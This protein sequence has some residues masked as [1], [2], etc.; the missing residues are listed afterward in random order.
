MILQYVRETVSSE[1]KIFIIIA[2]AI[3]VSFVFS[4]FLSAVFLKKVNKPILNLNRN[5][6]K[7]I[8]GEFA[9]CEKQE[10][11]Q[12]I[13]EMTDSFNTMAVTIS[14]REKQLKESRRLPTTTQALTT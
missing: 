10:S 14:E 1:N 4:V 11:Y 7:L 8:S 9:L 12:E 6:K 2:A 3:L 5:V 13:E